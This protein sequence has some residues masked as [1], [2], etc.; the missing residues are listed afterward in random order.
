M[1]MLTKCLEGANRVKLCQHC[2][3]KGDGWNKTVCADDLSPTLSTVQGVLLGF[4][5]VWVSLCACSCTHSPSLLPCK[6]N[7]DL[8]L[9]DS[10]TTQT[11]AFTSKVH[12]WWKLKH[13]NVDLPGD[14]EFSWRLRGFWATRSFP[15]DTSPVFNSL[16]LENEAYVTTKQGVHGKSPVDYHIVWVLLMWW[17]RIICG[18]ILQTKKTY[19]LLV[20]LGE[21]KHG[22]C[23]R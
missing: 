5:L 13:T 22:V 7:P 19:R 18:V 9:Q 1:G 2:L 23:L 20:C 11:K 4:F 16:I 6:K 17:Y 3:S 14:S 21:E 15:L 8:V 10:S 12:A